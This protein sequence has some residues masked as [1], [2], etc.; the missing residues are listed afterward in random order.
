MQRNGPTT[1]TKFRVINKLLLD[2]K[3]GERLLTTEIIIQLFDGEFLY[4]HLNQPSNQSVTKT[5]YDPSRVFHIGGR[6]LFATMFTNNHVE[7]TGEE[8]FGEWQTYVLTARPKDGDW[9]AKYWFDKATGVQVQL[10][11]TK[12]SGAPQLTMTV[13]KVDTN[14]QF[15]ADRFRYAVP[16]GFQVTDETVKP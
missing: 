9:T 15:P 8:T 5:F 7:L 1:L 6:E 2:S 4:L 13:E 11:E 14:P 12:L 16:E 10:I 3:P